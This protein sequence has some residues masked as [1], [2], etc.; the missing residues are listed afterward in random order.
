M[1][2]PLWVSTL[3]ATL[4]FVGSRADAGQAQSVLHIKIVLVDADRKAT[5][6][7]RH[8]LLISDNPATAPPRRIVTALDGTA[9]VRLRPGNYTVESDQPVAFQGKAYQWTQTLDIVAGRDAVLDLTANNAEVGAVTSAA[10]TLSLTLE[11]D[12][13]LLLPQWQD[14]VVALWT[15]IAH[16]SG[17]VI[18]AKGLV[19]TSQRVIGTATSVE[20]Q[21]TPEIKVA[22]RVLAADPAR[23]VAVLWIDPKVV[24]SLRPVPLGCAQ[25]AKLPDIVPNG[26]QNGTPNSIKDGQEIFA[27][28]V[29][30][31]EPKGMTSGTVS[32]VEPHAIVS[33]LRL[34]SGSAGGPVF[35]AAGSVIGITSVIDDDKDKDESRRGSSRVVRIDD[36]CEVVASAEKRMKDVMPPDGT[37]LPVEPVRPFP[38]DTLKDAVQRRAGSLSPYQMASSDFDV[39]FITPVLAYG[40]QYQSEQARGRERR[41]ERTP[42]AAPAAVMRPLMGFSNW[43][44]Y[45]ADSPPVLLVRVTPKQVEGFWTTVARGAALTQGVSVPPI[46]HVKSG[47]SRMRAFCG[48]AEVTPIHPFKLEQRVSESDAIYEGLYVF[49]PG[50]LGPHCAAVKLVMYSEKEPQKG[51]TRVVDPKVIQ[52]IWQ[53]FATYR[54]PVQGVR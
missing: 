26:A 6:V 11:A 33:D 30:L 20:V 18:D 9:D 31:R 28:G 46:K 4:L 29:P 40:A 14:S 47:F 32:R 42:D 51:E 27:I 8:A 21:I 35:S 52:Q 16:A 25:A 15:P 19:A 17:F 10:T 41:G 50:V 1:L 22:A 39:A 43:A 54:E 24:S 5:P 23:D 45:V 49:D 12:P 2:R 34:A 13:S 38:T 7:A 44:E 53:D 37:H 48:D 36:A 3:L